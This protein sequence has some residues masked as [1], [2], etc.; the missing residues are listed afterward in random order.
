MI[1]RR[2]IRVKVLQILYAFYTSPDH[3]VNNTE[4]ELFFSLQ[5]TYDLYHYM[6]ALV[7]EIEKF[8]E[9]RIELRRNKHRPTYEDLH[10]NTKFVDN[11]LIHQLKHNQSLNKYLEN[12]KLTWAKP[13]N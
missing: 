13:R 10:P 7:V 5:K 1:S 3:S 8:A 12:A 2:I 6:L 11:L 4:K 9:A